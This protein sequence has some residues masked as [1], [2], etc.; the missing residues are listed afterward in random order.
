MIAHKLFS[1]GFTQ[2]ILRAVVFFPVS[3][4]VGTATVRAI[5][6]YVDRH[7]F[8]VSLFV[9]PVSSYFVY[10]HRKLYST[11]FYLSMER[12]AREPNKSF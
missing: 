8:I 2:I 10:H 12:I 6:F 3:Y 11:L 4:Y 7:S 5:E 1:T 9:L